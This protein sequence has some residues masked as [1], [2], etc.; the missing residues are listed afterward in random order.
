MAMPM[1]LNEKTYELFVLLLPGFLSSSLYEAL[2]FRYKKDV[3]ARV[4]EM[5]AFSVFTYLIVRMM[6]GNVLMTDDYLSFWSLLW[7]LGVSMG[8]PILLAWSHINDIHM[9]V[10]RKIKSTTRTSNQSL[11]NDVFL[12][13]QKRFLRIT[14]KSDGKVYG[15]W[16]RYTSDDPNEGMVYLYDPMI[17]SEEGKRFPLEMDG[18]LF[19]REEI[20]RID[21]ERRGDDDRPER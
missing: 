6:H 7:I 18:I 14:S 11:W 19:S 15:G 10:L 16:P 4:F 2:V 21:F 9:R 20:G 3:L 1:E 8:L 13:N 12:H 17:I 5:V